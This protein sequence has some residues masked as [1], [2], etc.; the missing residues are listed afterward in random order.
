MRM[1]KWISLSTIAAV[2]LAPLIALAVSYTGSFTTNGEKSGAIRLRPGEK[3]TYSVAAA[4]GSVGFI[5][6][7]VLERSS[8]NA[9]FTNVQ[10]FTGT[11]LAPIS[12]TPT[13]GS[14]TNSD[15]YKSMYIRLRLVNIDDANTSDDMDYA[16]ASYE[17][18]LKKAQIKDGVV[19]NNDG[20]A[21]LTFKDSSVVIPTLSTTSLTATAIAPTTVDRT[22]QKYMF[23]VATNAKV[24]ATSGWTVAAAADTALVTCP[25]SQSAATLVVPVGPFKAG[26]TIT[27]FHLVGNVT[28][29]GNTVTVDAALRS[30]TAAAAAPTDV[31]VGAMTQVSATSNTILSSSNTT[32][33]SLTQVVGANQNFYMLITCTTGGSTTVVLQSIAV[34]VTEN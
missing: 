5:G 9:T 14:Y 6:T 11:A 10:T 17:N 16:L 3:A 29:A 25:A 30:G 7:T 19:E 13:T 32:K 28:S 31:S 1:K 21:L 24:G 23:P 8:N 27:G 20:T 12:T 2:V 34:T 4:A 26:W 18:T 22:S 33:A 15:P